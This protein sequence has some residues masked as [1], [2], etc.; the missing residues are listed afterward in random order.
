MQTGRGTFDLRNRDLRGGGKGKD[1]KGKDG[2]GKDGKGKED[3]YTTG[4]LYVGAAGEHRV[5][6]EL[7][8][9]GY[10]ASMT[11]VDR[12]IDIVARKGGH[13]FDIQVKTISK[14]KTG[15]Y[16]TSIKKK[17]FNANKTQSMYYV[18]V[19]KDGDAIDFVALPFS[20]MSKCIKE[21]NIKEYRGGSYQVSIRVHED[22]SV[23][24]KKE[25]VTFYKNNWNL[26]QLG[27][28]GA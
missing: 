18:F 15:A 25:T 9:R 17:T 24:I 13:V 3:E 5:E 8:F 28:G 11:S 1:G 21:G 26:G 2:K 14:H 16:I 23:T 19:L 6:S 10:D 12:G 27:Y 7:L 20:V 4:S 22:S